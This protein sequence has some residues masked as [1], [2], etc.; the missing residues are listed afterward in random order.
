MGGDQ[1][2]LSLKQVHLV[3]GLSHLLQTV[4]DILSALFLLMK[5]H[6]VP[7]IDQIVPVLRSLFMIF[8]LF[9]DVRPKSHQSLLL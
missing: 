6:V 3:G 7:D 2:I 1:R 8:S 5:I 4:H 9:K